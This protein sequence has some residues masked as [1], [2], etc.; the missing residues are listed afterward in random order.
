MIFDELNRI[1]TGRQGHEKV[2]DFDFE[3]GKI[4]IFMKSQRKL[5]ECNTTDLV[6]LRAG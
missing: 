6:P 2:N 1:T 5:K 3:S 4:D